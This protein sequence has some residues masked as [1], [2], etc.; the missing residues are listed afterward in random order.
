MEVT[1][2]H[3][4]AM[5]VEAVAYDGMARVAEKEAVE[6]EREIQWAEAQADALVR[7]GLYPEPLTLSL[8]LTPRPLPNPNP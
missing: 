2:S 7:Q 3:Q 4:V 8:S 1:P 5:Y 6:G